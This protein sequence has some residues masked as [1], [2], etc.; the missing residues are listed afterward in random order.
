MLTELRSIWAVASNLERFLLVIMPLAGAWD[1]MHG[2]WIDL[3][4]SIIALIFVVYSI[5]KDL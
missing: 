4:V 5:K 1:V 2:N 3:A